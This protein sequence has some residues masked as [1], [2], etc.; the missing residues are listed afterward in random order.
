M[1][2]GSREGSVRNANDTIGARTRA[3]RQACTG[4]A[5]SKRPL[6]APLQGEIAESLLND[7]FANVPSFSNA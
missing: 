2:S 7:L 1:F 3:L 6:Q 5:S 4:N